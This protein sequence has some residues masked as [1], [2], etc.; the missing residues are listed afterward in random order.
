LQQPAAVASGAGG[1]QTMS[2]TPGTSGSITNADVI[3]LVRGGLSEQLIIT[4]INSAQRKFDLSPT[5]CRNLTQ[6]H[7]S[8]NILKA[9]GDGSVIPCSPAAARPGTAPA[10]TTLNAAH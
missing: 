10:R 2:A 4:K 3:G 1:A 8:Q 5:G 6:A 7:V 9:M